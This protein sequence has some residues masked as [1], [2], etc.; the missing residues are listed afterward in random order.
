ML[1]TGTTST[2]PNSKPNELY[3]WVRGRG[4]LSRAQQLKT[5]P[6]RTANQGLVVTRTPQT[7]DPQNR[8]KVAREF[9]EKQQEQ[10]HRTGNQDLRNQKSTVEGGIEKMR[11]KMGNTQRNDRTKTEPVQ[12]RRPTGTIKAE[13]P[14]TDQ[15]SA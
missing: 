13:E 9:L 4:G 5:D 10:M 7:Q 11:T 14:N 15:K 6:K 1:Q 3:K 12:V 8:F 2:S